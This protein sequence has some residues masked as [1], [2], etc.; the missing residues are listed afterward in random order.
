MLG[1]LPKPKASTIVEPINDQ[2]TIVGDELIDPQYA[3][4]E[5]DAT[6]QGS[7]LPLHAT[8]ES[9]AADVNNC[10]EVTGM[11]TVGH[12]LHAYLWQLERAAR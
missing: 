12:S 11:R 2:G 1:P 9:F 7:L 4:G 8:A 3:A 5:W 10:G 6:L